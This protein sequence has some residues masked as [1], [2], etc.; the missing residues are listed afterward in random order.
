MTLDYNQ[1]RKEFKTK[2]REEV[3]E[4]NGIP[5]SPIAVSEVKEEKIDVSKLAAARLY[6][7]KWKPRS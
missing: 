2:A 4:R 6:A 7:M 1:L 5:T 3:R